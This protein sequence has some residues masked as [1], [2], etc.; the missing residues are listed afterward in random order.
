MEMPKNLKTGRLNNLKTTHVYRSKM[1]PPQDKLSESLATLKKLQVKGIIAIHTK[2]MTRTHR[3]HLIKNGFIK[4]VM[5]GWYISAH[6]E[7][8]TG[9][10]TAWYASFC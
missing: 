3:E 10:S 9:E 2:N 1:P 7:E 4:E 8:P 5:K 6:P